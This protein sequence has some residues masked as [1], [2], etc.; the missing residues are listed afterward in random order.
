MYYF[1][2]YARLDNVEGLEGKNV[3]FGEVEKHFAEVEEVGEGMVDEGDRELF[4]FEFGEFFLDAANDKVEYI[5]LLGGIVLLAVEAEEDI[6]LDIVGGF[7][8]D[9]HL[10]DIF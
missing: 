2:N 7:G 4:V 3:F 8:E 5:L 6:A 10:L 9:L 1:C